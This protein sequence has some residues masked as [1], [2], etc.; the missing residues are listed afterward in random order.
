MKT[1]ET[2][3]LILRNFK[4]SDYDDVY[5]FLSQRKEDAF[6]AYPDITYENGR[7][8][9][10]YRVDNDEFV[11]I[12]LKETGKI[13]GNVYFGKRDFEAKELGYIVN[14][15]Y[16]RKGYATE[17]VTEVLRSGFKD[18]VHRV[19]AECDPRNEC[20]WKLLESMGFT[21]EAFFKQNVYF[22]KDESGNPIW[23]DTYV[24][25]LLKE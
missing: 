23:Q 12:Q 15:D 25:C 4:E 9:L 22:R 8:H 20:S 2:E 19:F 16:Q 18:G 14:K 6:E 17:A 11:A 3:R 13:I 5:E 24:Y 21:R 7:E 10:K 1:M